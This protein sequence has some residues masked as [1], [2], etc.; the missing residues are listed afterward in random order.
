[1]LR[2]CSFDR[3]VHIKVVEGQVIG[4]VLL[5][6]FLHNVLVVHVEL[7]GYEALKHLAAALEFRSRGSGFGVLGFGILEFRV[8]DFGVQGLEFG[9]WDYGRMT[10]GIVC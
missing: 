3:Q 7:Q 8:W 2:I 10:E 9:F 6:H 4:R 5:C 1:M